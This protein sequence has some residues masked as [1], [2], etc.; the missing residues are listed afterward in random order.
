MALAYALWQA[1]AADGITVCGRRPDP[2][3]H[4]LFIEGTARYVFGLEKPEVGTTVAVL[5]LPDSVLPQM[6]LSL[7]AQGEAPSG[8]SAFHLSGAVGTDLMAPLREKGY[9]IGSLH[10]LQTVA[11]PVVGAGQLR[12]IYFAVSGEPLA[13]GAARRIVS[14]L[15][16]TAVTVPVARRPLYHAAAVLA[17]NYLA[18]LMGAAGRLM[19]QAGIPE[20]EALLALLPLARGSLENLERLGPAQALTGP[21]SRGDVET[22]RLHLRS[23]EPRERAV[24]AA[25]GPEIVAVAR[26]AG[27]EDEVAEE[28]NEIFKVGR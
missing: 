17:S 24:Y 16:S 4:P 28:L 20:E 5:A 27:L 14:R 7:S 8:C 23:M 18:G 25:L 11:D 22:V 2:P 9:S 3:P 21:I 13:L 15:E 10:P 19:V 1:D 26:E 12:R 6:A